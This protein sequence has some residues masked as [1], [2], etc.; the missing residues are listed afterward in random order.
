[1]QELNLPTYSFKFK[2]NENKI[3][4]FDIARKKYVVLTPE[5][6]VRQHLLHYLVHDKKYPISRIAVE[7]KI[8]V[9][10]LTKR[11]DIVAFNRDGSPYLI[12]E[13][14]APEIP[15]TQKSFD[16]IARYN[17]SLKGLY[18]MVSNGLDHF[19]CKTNDSK[20]GYVFLKSLPDMP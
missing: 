14:K 5:E 2:S 20:D 19:Y 7:K 8:V 9:N 17:S 13:C 10:G 11:T 6:W 12:V 4:I 15:I 1:M 18:L 16:Q 3:L